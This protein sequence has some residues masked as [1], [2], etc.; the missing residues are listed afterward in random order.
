MEE[1]LVVM[2]LTGV[3]NTGGYVNARLYPSLYDNRFHG[4]WVRKA[5]LVGL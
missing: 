1:G 5:V 2:S 3:Y 4:S